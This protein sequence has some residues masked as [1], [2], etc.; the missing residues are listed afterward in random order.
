MP[1]DNQKK[2]DNT[3]PNERMDYTSDMK[4][5]IKAIKNDV[6]YRIIGK[7]LTLRNLIRINN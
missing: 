4:L 3:A 6:A 5:V 7:G 2:I 1:H